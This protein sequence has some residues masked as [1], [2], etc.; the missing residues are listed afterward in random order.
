MNVYKITEIFVLFSS[1]NETE[2]SLY[3]NLQTTYYIIP[4]F[5]WI[6]QVTV[7]SRD[8]VTRTIREVCHRLTYPMHTALIELTQSGFRSFGPWL[9]LCGFTVYWWEVKWGGGGMKFNRALPAIQ[10]FRFGSDRYQTTC[11]IDEKIGQLVT[12]PIYSSGISPWRCNYIF[13][14][15]LQSLISKFVA[16]GWMPFTLMEKL[17]LQY[18]FAMF[19]KSFFSRFVR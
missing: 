8:R 5:T 2:I 9:R 3:I 13:T 16:L 15:C 6:L 17:E 19:L 7:I 18:I 14:I 1:A 12:V 10:R 4:W 11:G